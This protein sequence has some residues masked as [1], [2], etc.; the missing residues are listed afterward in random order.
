MSISA[1]PPPVFGSCRQAP[2]DLRIPARQ[3]RSHVDDLAQPPCVDQLL[4]LHVGAVELHHV[5][6]LEE[7][8]VLAAG[9]H[10]GLALFQ[11][12]RQRLLAQDVLAGLGRHRDLLGVAVDRRGDVDRLDPGS[13]SSSCSVA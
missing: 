7:D 10:R 12:H 4:D 2:A 5:A 13:A 6:F 1:P 3:L 9:G 8:V 11:I